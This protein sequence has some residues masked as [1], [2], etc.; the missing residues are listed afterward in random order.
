MTDNI[1]VFMLIAV[2]VVR[3]MMTLYERRD[4]INRIMAKDAAEYRLMTDKKKKH[5]PT[6]TPVQIAY[7]RNQ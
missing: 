3:E 6:K 7:E 4:L 5:K 2:I 1:I